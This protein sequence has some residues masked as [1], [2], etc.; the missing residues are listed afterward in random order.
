MKDIVFT[1][2]RQRRELIILGVC[3]VVACLLNIWA[4]A[5]YDAP[6]SE[7][8]SAI[9][10]VLIFAAVL[11]AITVGVRMLVYGIRLLLP[12]KNRN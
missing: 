6:W 8:Y 3:V 11:Y 10:Y 5:S 4:I 7:L 9:F 12:R 2:A 1:Q